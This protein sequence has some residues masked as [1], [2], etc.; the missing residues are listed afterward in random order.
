MGCFEVNTAMN[1]VLSNYGSMDLTMC[2]QLCMA[3]NG[4]T[5]SALLELNNCYC[6]DVTGLPDFHGNCIEM[7]GGNNMQL[8]GQ[9]GFVQAYSLGRN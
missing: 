1:S 2:K 8:C 6:G 4:T 9:S 5:G 3:T 7:C